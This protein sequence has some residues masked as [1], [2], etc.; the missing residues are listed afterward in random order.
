MSEKKLRVGI[1]GGTG[2]VGQ[3]FV[4]LLEDHPWF[5]VTAIAASPR[6]AGLRYGEAVKDRWRM[7][8]DIPEAVRDLLVVNVNEIDRIAKEVDFVFS[9]VEMSKDE[10]KRIEEDYARAEVPVVSNN[11]AHR[12]TPDVPMIM[13]ELN[14]EH[15]DVIEY[16]KKRLGSKRGF[17]VVKPNCSIQSYVPMLAAWR[18]FGPTEVVACTYQAI[19]GAGK[20]FADWPEMVENLIPY[21]GGEEEKSEQEPLRIF[22]AVKDGAIVA[23][24]S[25]VITCQ[26]LRV[27]VLDGHT[28][29]VFVNFQ[30]K[31]SKEALIEKLATFKGKPQE[32][33]LPSAPRRFMRYLEDDDRPQVA[34]DV[35]CENGMGISVG[36]LREDH[37]FDYK[38]VA[39]S[40]NTIRGAAGGAV[41]TAELLKA[42]GYMG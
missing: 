32:L 13:P 41:L 22:G 5:E 35:G 26:C 36:R 30:N 18:E 23:A 4:D 17:V 6:S 37:V 33:S 10:I 7:S 15:L 27:P 14:A 24:T 34:L 2:M 28:A 1:L 9:A 12:W 21:I 31:P 8:A 11:S 40:H 19:S 25:P 38:F 39:L 29:A 3:R 16:Q 42:L 20:T